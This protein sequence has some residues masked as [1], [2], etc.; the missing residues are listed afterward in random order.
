MRRHGLTEHHFFLRRSVESMRRLPV[1]L[2]TE[3]ISK[4][5]E[6]KRR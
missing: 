3:H 1:T 2:Q 5:T 6:A 4:R